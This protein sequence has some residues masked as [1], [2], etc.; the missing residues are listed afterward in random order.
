M[1][2]RGVCHG[3]AALACS[4]ANSERDIVRVPPVVNGLWA[5]GAYG[6]YA[7]CA[8]G[9]ARRWQCMTEG[10]DMSSPALITVMQMRYVYMCSSCGVIMLSSAA[11][12]KRPLMV[13]RSEAVCCAD[14]KGW[15]WVT[16]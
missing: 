16:T 9:G 12:L 8:D 7:R 6:G 2:C 14:E 13:R 4:A 11:K 5:Y 10:D 1:P 15:E 3:T